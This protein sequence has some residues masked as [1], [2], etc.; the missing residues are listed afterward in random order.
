[1]TRR[2]FTLLEMLASIAIV[3]AILSA[4]TTTFFTV[5]RLREQAFRR[6]ESAAP[7]EYAAAILR[8]DLACAVPP[9]GILAGTFYGEMV[10]ES[11]VR[12]DTLEFFSAR[13][14]ITDREEEPFGDIVKIQYSL[15][16]EDELADEL[17][18]LDQADSV[19][20]LILTRSVTRNLLPL[21]EEDPV[22]EP[23]LRGARLLQIAYYDGE[24]WQDSWDSTT[25][26]NAAPEAVKLR[27]EFEPANSGEPAA[28]PFEMVVAIESKAIMEQVATDAS[29]SM[30]QVR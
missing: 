26:E 10:N 30:G 29:N 2:A 16:G 17:G 8:R 4:L 25:M 1:M 27:I 11:G 21:V 19:P 28:A 23:L 18:P 6:I 7:D 12:M 14:E 3:S 24:V 15:A 5:M 9:A 20:G 13:G 22:R